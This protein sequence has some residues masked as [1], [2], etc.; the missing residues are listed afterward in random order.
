MARITCSYVLKLGAEEVRA[1]ACGHYIW[2]RLCA[3]RDIANLIFRRP[4]SLPEQPAILE[5]A[6]ARQ[7][8][9]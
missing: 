5:E 1:V 3:G 7:I 2:V 8:T 4:D 9:G 6:F